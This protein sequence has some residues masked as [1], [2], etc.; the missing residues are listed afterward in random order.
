MESQLLMNRL[1]LQ[2]QA[3]PTQLA[4]GGIRSLQNDSSRV[5]ELTQL[6][7]ALNGRVRVDHPSVLQKRHNRS[8]ALDQK[9]TVPVN[10]DKSLEAEADEMG[11]RAVQTGESASPLADLTGLRAAAPVQKRVVQRLVAFTQ[12]SVGRRIFISSRS[13]SD[14]GSRGTI[15][16][17][18]RNVDHTFV[19]EFDDDRGVHYRVA[20]DEMDYLDRIPAFAAYHILPMLGTPPVPGGTPKL[21]LGDVSR[22]NIANS[23]S[24]LGNV[25][26]GYPES[27][28]AQ[29]ASSMSG[30]GLA[31]AKKEA[32]AFMMLKSSG[33]PARLWEQ[34]DG[35]EQSTLVSSGHT[36]DFVVG[37][38]L[39]DAFN[40][41]LDPRVSPDKRVATTV[42]SIK[43]NASTKFR[44]Y[45]AGS[46]AVASLSE[47]LTRSQ[48]NEVVQQVAS[49]PVAGQTLVLIY[50]GSLTVLGAPI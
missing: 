34:L 48:F 1:A 9:Q 12:A 15:I 28:D 6:K 27:M 22:F 24:A 23:H 41:A 31:N 33:L 36:P 37:S 45:K 17:P 8:L 39:A 50:N 11:E 32:S 30:K 20:P 43:S 21:G 49:I 5:R 18:S 19:V 46:I 10:D 47:L 7:D 14:F 40:S 42:S 2:R 4:N 44:K 35:P 3:K 26:G 16:R 25:F 13:A 29:H 38:R